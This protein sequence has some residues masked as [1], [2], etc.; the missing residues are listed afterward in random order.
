MP[1]LQKSTYFGGRLGPGRI[2]GPDRRV[3]V[4]H[5]YP[6]LRRV[7]ACHTPK[8]SDSKRGVVITAAVARGYGRFFGDGFVSQ[9][10][11]FLLSPA[12]VRPVGDRVCV[13]AARAQSSDRPDTNRTW[14]VIGGRWVGERS[15]TIRRCRGAPW[16]NAGQRPFGDPRQWANG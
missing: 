16:A 5:A 3:P 12:S 7:K 14:G 2:L 6:R 15:A 1:R 13:R 4:T 11:V 10:R 9:K 8:N